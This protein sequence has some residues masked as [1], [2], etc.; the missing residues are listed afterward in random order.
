MCSGHTRKSRWLN[1]DDKLIKIIF[2][3]FVV[4][5]NEPQEQSEKLSERESNISYEESSLQIF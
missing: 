5:L 1:F 4:V 3:S 2:V